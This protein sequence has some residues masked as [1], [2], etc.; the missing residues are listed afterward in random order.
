MKE[1][2]ENVDM[3]KPLFPWCLNWAVAFNLRCAVSF[4]SSSRLVEMNS[5]YVHYKHELLWKH[6]DEKKT[7]YKKH[8]V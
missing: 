7:T 5:P 3:K 8:K 2:S 1:R 6:K 4:F